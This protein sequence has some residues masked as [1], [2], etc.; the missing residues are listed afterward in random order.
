VHVYVGDE[1]I[2]TWPLSDDT[3]PNVRSLRCF[4]AA[5]DTMADLARAIRANSESRRGSA[6][7]FMRGR[8]SSTSVATRSGRSPI[9]A[10]R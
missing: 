10:I 5:R 4:F 6:P 9:S 2:V 7:A 8:S 1:V 3:D